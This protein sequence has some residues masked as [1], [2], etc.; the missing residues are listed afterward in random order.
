MFSS[1]RVLR[2]S[3]VNLTNQGLNKIF[4][5]LCENL[6]KVRQSLDTPANCLTVF[7]MTL[8]CLSPPPLPP[9]E[10]LLQTTLHDPL[11]SLS[12]QL[13]CGSARRRAHPGGEIQ[14][15]CSLEKNKRH[16]NEMFIFF[17]FLFF[18]RHIVAQ[19]AVTAVAMTFDKDQT[20]EKPSEKP[21]SKGLIR[22]IVCHVR[23]R[24]RAKK[25]EMIK[26]KNLN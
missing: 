3:N 23:K 20:Q 11:L 10:F 2:L 5:D 15:I 1:V 14:A 7:M 4:T 9:T 6:L 21:A 8:N 26:I 17:F 18:S 16:L 19:V 13:H 22:L 12:S 24:I 25:R